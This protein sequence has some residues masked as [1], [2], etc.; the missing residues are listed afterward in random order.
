[1]TEKQR[2]DMIE[3][4]RLAEEP[5]GYVDPH[6]VTRFI[7]DLRA[8]AKFFAKKRNRVNRHDDSR[9]EPLYC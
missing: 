1:M 5:G 3:T 6:L 9:D 7:T 8:I 4:D 2:Q